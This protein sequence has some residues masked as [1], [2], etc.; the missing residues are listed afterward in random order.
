MA[1]AAAQAF[2]DKQSPKDRM[3]IIDSWG[4]RDLTDEWYNN[5][6]AAGSVPAAGAAPALPSETDIRSAAQG[7]SEDFD[8]FNAGTVEGWTRDYYDAAASQ[9]AGR[10]QFRSSRGAPGFFDKPT[11]CPPG[12][13][14]SGG[15]E[16]DPCTTTGYSTPNPWEQG[17]GGA[18]AGAGAAPSADPAYF[19]QDDPLQRMLVN[20]MASGGGSFT[21]TTK[22]MA[23]QGG[24]VWSQTGPFAGSP[25][26]AAL[27]ALTPSPAHTPAPVA[28]PPPAA[29]PAPVSAPTI[30]PVQSATI[31]A[32][33]AASSSSFR[34]VD[35]PNTPD[36]FGI[37]PGTGTLEDLV[38]PRRARRDARIGG[39]WF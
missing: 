26:T 4:G 34:A 38:N 33:A 5:A 22:G 25:A 1:S 35:R 3:A 12:Q 16:S 8:R 14:P 27:S 23:L 9:A 28:A 18:G 10:P 6:K 36:A 39:N 15:S 7:K 2:F 24:G 29:A 17:G 13:G 19:G 32:P 31:G 11:E 37:S 21:G 30:A 20:Q